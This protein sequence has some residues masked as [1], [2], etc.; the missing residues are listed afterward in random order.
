MDREKLVGGGLIKTQ[1]RENIAASLR[2][3]RSRSVGVDYSLAIVLVI[4][5]RDH[6]GAR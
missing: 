3:C 5:I 1:R 2:R 4:G 6:Q